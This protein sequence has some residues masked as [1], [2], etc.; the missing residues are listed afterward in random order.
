MDEGHCGL[1][2]DELSPTGRGFARYATGTDAHRSRPRAAPTGLANALLACIAA[3]RTIAERRMRLVNGTLPWSW[4][5]PG[6]ALPWRKNASNCARGKPVRRNP[7]RTD[8]QGAGH[9][10]VPVSATTIV[11]AILRILAAKEGRPPALCSDRP[12]GQAHGRGKC[13]D[14]ALADL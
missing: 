6:K 3:E 11:N 13:P 7:A 10:A 8:V 2:T 4:I 14:V 1:P 5:D 9:L 12:D